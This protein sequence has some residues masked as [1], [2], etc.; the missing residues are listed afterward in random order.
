EKLDALPPFPMVFYKILDITEGGHGSRE[1]LLRALSLDQAIVAKV[2][3]VSNSAYYGLERQVSSIDRAV[4][5]IGENTV[6]EVAIY[7]ATYGLLRSPLP[8]YRISAGQFWEHSVTTSLAAR[9]IAARKIP[10]ICEKALVAGLLHDVGKLAMNGL[11]DL[12]LEDEIQN[13][14]EKGRPLDEIERELFGI[15][16]CE[17]GRL[18]AEKWSFPDEIRDAISYHHQ[19]RQ[20]GEHLHLVYLV[21]VADRISHALSAGIKI[22]DVLDRQS[23]TVEWETAIGALGLSRDEAGLLF[24]DVEAELENA[25]AFLEL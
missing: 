11:I 9:G 12:E 19:P 8:R 18:F 10:Q 15:D 7:C 16:H 5:L 6:R 20:S 14:L 17:V 22:K 24:S 21:Q 23:N 4:A 13:R 2:L 1:E 3:H 25:E